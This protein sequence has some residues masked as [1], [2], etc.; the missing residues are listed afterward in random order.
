MDGA[1]SP[2]F[3][4]SRLRYDFGS[5]NT[6]GAVLTAR[7]DGADF[8]RV[9]AAD[10][11]FYHSKLYFA[12][13]QAAQSWTDSSRNR[14]NGSLL[15][16]RLGQDRPRVGISLHAQIT[17]SRLQSRGRFREPHGDHRDEGVQQAQL[18][19]GAG[20]TGSD[21][22]L[23][24]RPRSHLEQRW[25][26]SWTSREHRVDHADGDDSWRMAAEWRTDAQL[27]RIRSIALCWI[28]CAAIDRTQSFDTRRSR[29]HGPRRTNWVRRSAYDSHLPTSSA[30]RRGSR[31][32][33]SRFFV[34]PRRA[35]APALMPLS[36]SVQRQR[37]A[38]RSSFRD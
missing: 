27:L 16:A 20:R 36:T 24:F 34:K 12:Q 19:W 25:C 29:F 35:T 8:S 33:R 15:Q 13:F 10:F 38:A 22:R 6:L 14:M 32:V 7:E 11:R 1:H 9:A 31:E 30:A 23:F 37:S 21:L 26:R 2:L 28:D 4:V 3:G 18:L 5:N 17:R